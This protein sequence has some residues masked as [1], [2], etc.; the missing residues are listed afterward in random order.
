MYEAVSSTPKLESYQVKPQS[1][2]VSHHDLQ[3]EP[4][5]ESIQAVQRDMMGTMQKLV[6]Q[7]EKLEAAATQQRFP[8]MQRVGRSMPSNYGRGRQWSPVGQII[9]QRSN[10]PGHYVHGC[11]TNIDKQGLGNWNQSSKLNVSNVP[12]VNINNVSSYFVVGK[13][14]KTPVSFL[15]DTSVRVSLF[16]GNVWDRTVPG[17]TKIELKGTYRLVGV[18][19]ILINVR[20]TVSAKVSLETFTFKQQFVIADEITA[21]AL[22]GMDFLEANK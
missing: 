3:K 21:E 17:N 4:V 1:R 11:A 2:S 8:T 18:D 10:Q 12:N 7:M 15:V 9:F 5:V 22:L 20:G 19:R 16:R 6:E 14:F 13:V